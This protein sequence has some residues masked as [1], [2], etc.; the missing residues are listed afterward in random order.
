MNP[1]NYFSTQAQLDNQFNHFLQRQYNIA[2]ADKSLYPFTV[3][4]PYHPWY[5]KLSIA[6]FG[7]SS[8]DQAQRFR[9]QDIAYRDYN[10]IKVGVHSPSVASL[11]IGSPSVFHSAWDDIQQ[12][13]TST[14]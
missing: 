2:Q 8:I 12:T 6:M 7:E 3:E 14:S 13:N 11:G 4:N 9:Y 1:F 10:T 5:K